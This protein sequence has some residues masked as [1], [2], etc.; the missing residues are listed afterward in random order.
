MARPACSASLC[1]VVRMSS[2]LATRSLTLT[3]KPTL[4]LPGSANTCRADTLARDQSNAFECVRRPKKL[5]PSRVW[6]SPGPLEVQCGFHLRL[7]MTVAPCCECCADKILCAV[8]AQLGWSDPTNYFGHGNVHKSGVA[9][10]QSGVLSAPKLIVVPCATSSAS[11]SSENP[12]V[13]QRVTDGVICVFHAPFTLGRSIRKR[14]AIRYPT[15]IGRMFRKA[16]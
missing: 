7:V 13:T 4:R 1:S 8:T 10:A 5:A 2:R 11:D 6:R 3:P 15:S 14:D 16:A 9:P 12:R